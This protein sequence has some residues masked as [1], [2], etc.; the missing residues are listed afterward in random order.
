MS[1]FVVVFEFF[2]P[3][4]FVIFVMMVFYIKKTI[5]FNTYH[6]YKIHLY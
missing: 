2:V 3:V 5:G 1:T 6:S 4:M